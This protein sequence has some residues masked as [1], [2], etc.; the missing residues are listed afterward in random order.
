VKATR[1][2]VLT[3]AAATAAVVTLPMPSL[4]IPGLTDVVTLTRLADEG[5]YA[6][7]HLPSL[8]T[9]RLAL[10]WKFFLDDELYEPAG[11]NQIGQSFIKEIY[12]PG[13]DSGWAVVYVNKR[14]DG[15]VRYTTETMIVHGNWRIETTLMDNRRSL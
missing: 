12:A 11:S 1:R 14:V 9:N 6:C 2:Q 8:P 7:S 4:A 10:D 3:G 13:D 5:K 15:E